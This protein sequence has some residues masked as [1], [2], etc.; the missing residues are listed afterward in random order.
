MWYT[1]FPLHTTVFVLLSKLFILFFSFTFHIHAYFL[2]E[3][4]NESEYILKL[5]WKY[6]I[7]CGFLAIHFHFECAT[8][9]LV[10]DSF[11]VLFRTTTT[12]NADVLCYFFSS[13]A[14]AHREAD[15]RFVLCMYTEILRPNTR[16]AFSLSSRPIIRK[17]CAFWQSKN[18][19]RFTYKIAKK[20]QKH[21]DRIF[22]IWYWVGESVTSYRGRLRGGVIIESYDFEIEKK[23]RRI[24][25]TKFPTANI[26]RVDE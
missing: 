14:L 19:T 12:T 7:R 8:V 20:L 26:N 17:S 23:Q 10:K 13:I 2:F 18:K 22:P 15:R 1:Y 25:I 9:V 16:R 11:R 6:E 3:L 21:F 4:V 5:K 24:E